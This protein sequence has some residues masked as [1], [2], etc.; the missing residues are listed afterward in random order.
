MTAAVMFLFGVIVGIT[1]LAVC[2][3][4][5]RQAAAQ[6]ATSRTRATSSNRKAGRGSL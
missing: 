3:A 4:W 6:P 2:N 1:F 5:D